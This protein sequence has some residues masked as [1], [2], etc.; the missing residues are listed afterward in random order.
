MLNGYQSC[1]P[2]V[3]WPTYLTS[4]STPVAKTP[5]TKQCSLFSH[6]KAAVPKSIE[7]SVSVEQQLVNYL[8]K[9]NQPDFDSEEITLEKLC[10]SDQYIA[11]VP[12]LQRLFCVPATSAPVER[13]FSQ[14]GLIMRPHRARMSDSTLE[15]LIFKCNKNLW[16]LWK[17]QSALSNNSSITWIRSTSQILIQRKSHWKSYYQSDQVYIAVVPLL[18]KLFCIPA[19]GFQS[20]AYSHKAA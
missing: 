11:V 9:I 1:S 16:S 18:Q 8:D 14:S 5:A 13:I 10:K 7:R 17:D 2:T 19:T 6:Y 12:L 20:N 4:Y 15:T 3:T